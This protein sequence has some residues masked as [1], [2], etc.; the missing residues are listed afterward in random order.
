M[1]NIKISV[2]T[3]AIT[4]PVPPVQLY[5]QKEDTGVFGGIRSCAPCPAVFVLKTEPHVFLTKQWQ[6][7]LIAINYSMDLGSVASLLHYRY[8]FCN[9]TGFGDPTDLRA[10]FITGHNMFYKSPQFDKVRTCSRNVLTGTEVGGFLKVKTFDSRNPPPLKPGKDYPKTISEINPDDYLFMP[11][12]H[13]EMFLVANVVMSDGRVMQFPRGGLYEWTGDNDPYSFLPH[14]SN[15][16][17]GS[18]L[19]PLKNL[20]KL[21]LGSPIPSPYTI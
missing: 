21:P 20:I 16:D 4:Q 7:F 12:T 9:F 6:Y 13:R 10:N 3:S 1:T 15:P 5:M 14:I 17:Y 8:A 19:Y 18:V 2:T 11:R